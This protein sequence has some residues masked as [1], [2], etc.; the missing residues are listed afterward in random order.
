MWGSC[1][2]KLDDAFGREMRGR[3]R[4]LLVD[5]RDIIHLQ[6]AALDLPPRLAVRCDQAGAHEGGKNAERRFEFTV[7]DSIVGSVSASAPSSKV[8]RTVTAASSAVARAQVG[9]NVEEIG[10]VGAHDTAL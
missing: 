6:A 5:N 4:H 8:R 10:L 1:Q 7:W 2:A 9:E 3:E